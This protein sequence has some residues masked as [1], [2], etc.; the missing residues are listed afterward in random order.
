MLE[1]LLSLNL[2]GICCAPGRRCGVG[3]NGTTCK[4]VGKATH[5]SLFT[6]SVF[7]NPHYVI[8]VFTQRPGE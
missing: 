1:I 6:E 8:P 4:H 3:A 5:P 7:P 2:Y